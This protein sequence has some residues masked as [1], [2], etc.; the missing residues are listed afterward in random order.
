MTYVPKHANRIS[1]YGLQSALPIHCRATQNLQQD[2][3]AIG[4]GH[5]DDSDSKLV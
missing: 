2:E 4:I 3:R 1:L 5:I